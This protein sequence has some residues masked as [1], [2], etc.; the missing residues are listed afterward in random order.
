MR[1][2]DWSSDVCSS[3]LTA[4][5][6]RDRAADVPLLAQF[7]LYP[8]VDLKTRYPSGELF[9]RGYFL[10][11]ANLK[12]FNACYQPDLESWRASP[13]LGDQS[14]MPS[15]LIL[16]AGLDPLRDHGRSYAHACIEQGVPVVYRTAEG[17]IPGFINM[18]KE[19]PS[20]VGSIHAVLAL[21]LP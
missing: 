14:G 12:W 17:N 15:T 9:G 11:S 19:I 8:G 3:D 13:L 1:I 21:F 5:A 18:E 2:S 16:T 10:E 6:L 4:M 7:P 20:S